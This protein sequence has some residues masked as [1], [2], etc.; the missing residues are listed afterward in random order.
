[1]FSEA[2]TILF[3]DLFC[4]FP[5]NCLI[6]KRQYVRLLKV[7]FLKYFWFQGFTQ[8]EIM[9]IL[10]KRPNLHQIEPVLIKESVLFCN[11]IGFTHKDLLEHP[12]LL[13]SHPVLK[14][15]QYQSLLDTGCEVINPTLLSR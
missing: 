8:T 3:S 14:F 5:R 11:K 9:K 4:M 15:N 1:M 2:I 13:V 10:E 7:F 12:G 6:L